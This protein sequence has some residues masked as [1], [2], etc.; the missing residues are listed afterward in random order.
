MLNN[1]W[2]KADAESSEIQSHKKE[3][4]EFLDQLVVKRKEQ[5]ALHYKLHKNIALQH[6]V[7][8]NQADRIYDA[9][10]KIAELEKQLAEAQSMVPAKAFYS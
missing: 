8:L 7:T 9:K 1:A 10:E 2:G 4:G 5:Q 6:C 3:I